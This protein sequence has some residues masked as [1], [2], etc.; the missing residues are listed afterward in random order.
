MPGQHALAADPRIDTSHPFGPGTL[1]QLRQATRPTHEALDALLPHGLRALHDYRRYLGALLPLADWL[2]RGWNPAWPAPL[3]RWNDAA[4]LACLRRD[5][6][7]LGVGAAPADARPATTA[8]EWLGGCYV[9]EGSALGA[10]LLS[11]HAQALAQAHPEVAG[12]RSFLAHI[13]ADSRRWPRFVEQLDALPQ[14]QAAAAVA[15]AETGF[16]IV[17]ARLA[18]K[19]SQA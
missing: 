8:A 11:R 17:H 4:R 7:A 5:A 1:P 3:A 13:T 2:A 12:A 6:A 18:I 16:G 19:G 15:G 9:I 10:R 14:A